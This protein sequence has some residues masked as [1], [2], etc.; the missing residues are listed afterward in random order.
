[1]A[2]ITFTDGVGSVT[3][4]NGKAG[5]GSRF[6]NWTPGIDRVG[7]R[8]TGLGTG[9][10]YEYLFRQDYT[11]AFAI[12]HIPVAALDLVVRFIAWAMAGNTFTL[13]TGDVAART[14]VC[15]IRPDTTPEV[16]M[17]D[18]ALL[19]YR[20]NVSVISAASPPEF[21]ACIYRV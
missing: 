14:H 8:K 1:M 21:L 15:R 12:E 2:T 7:D 11:A 5:P 20:L 18:R 16:A 13:N 9:I 17:E 6:S 10:T 4:T 3:L 19:E